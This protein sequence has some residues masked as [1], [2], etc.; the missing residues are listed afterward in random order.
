MIWWYSTCSN[1]ILIFLLVLCLDLPMSVDAVIGEMEVL[2]DEKT[3]GD[4][5]EETRLLV[6]RYGLDPLDVPRRRQP[7]QRYSGPADSYD[8][9][10]AEAYY[11]PK[12]VALHDS[13]LVNLHDRYD[14]SSNNGLA[15]YKPLEEVLATGKCTVMN[16]MNVTSKSDMNI[17]KHYD[18]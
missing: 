11:R 3:F 6:E 1:D 18:H 2:R 9:P 17:K 7:P 8:P 12:Y 5:F 16:M 13:I 15:E 10:S 4:L 14:T